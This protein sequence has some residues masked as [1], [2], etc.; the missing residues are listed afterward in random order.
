VLALVELDLT[1]TDNNDTALGE[2]KHHA[3][4]ALLSRT[5]PYPLLFESLSYITS[6]TFTEHH[7]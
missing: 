3:A 2:T 6:G 7:S 1:N 5:C 4:D